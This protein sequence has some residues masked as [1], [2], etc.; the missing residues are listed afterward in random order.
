M[1]DLK[2]NPWD[3]YSPAPVNPTSAPTAKNPWDAYAAPADSAPT[4][5]TPADSAPVTPGRG[6]GA[7]PFAYRTVADLGG[8]PV[9]LV[10]WG[11]SKF[12]V[13]VSKEPFG[14]SA[15]IEN[16]LAK[17]GETIRKPM[18]PEVGQEPKTL[19]EYIGSGLGNA[20][21]FLIPGLSLARLAASSAR[22]VVAAVG[23]QLANA[24]VAAPLSY[25]AA[26]LASGAG[27]GAG[28]YAAEQ[29]APDSKL[30]SFAG[31]ILG[32]LAPS[33]TIPIAKIATGTGPAIAVGKFLT[34][35][36][37][38]AGSRV[39]A[40]NRVQS[41]VADPAF[42]ARA[43]E[44]PSISELT[45][46]QRAGDTGLLSLEK[47]VAETNA[48]K[49]QELRD[50]AEAAQQTLLKEARAL[51]GDPALTKAFF[52]ARRSQ[53]GD[54]LT[55]SVNQARTRAQE[56]IAELDPKASAEDAS[57][58]VRG[59]FD[60]AYDAARAQENRLWRDISQDVQVDTAPLFAKFDEIVSS[61]PR[62]QQQDI[63]AY[64]RSFLDKKNKE[65]LNDLETPSELQGFRSELLAIE[66]RARDAGDRNQA[67]LARE[68]AD[69]TLDAMSSMKNVGDS[70]DAARSFSRQLNET[71]RQGPVGRLIDTTGGALTVPPEMTLTS[72]I[73]GGGVRGGVAERG[74]VA[75]TGE[76]PEVKTAIQDFLTRDLRDRVVTAEGRI[77]P[78][79][80]ET[81]MRRNET[82]LEQ[83]P[84]IRQGLTDALA[85]QAQVGRREGFEKA[86]S[87]QMRTAGG[88]P[89]AQFLDDVS[90]VFK[91]ENP[92]EVAISL[93][94]TAAKDT[95]GQ[96]LL[97]LRGAFVDD[98]FT[99]ARSVTT[100][101]EVFRGSVIVDALKNPKQRG[102]FEA[103]LGAD[104]LKRLEQIG[105][106]FVALERTRG[107]LPSVGGVVGDIPNRIL[108]TLARFGG[109]WFGRL[110]GGLQESAIMSARSR[111]FMR[112]LT[113]DRAEKLISK[114]VTDPELFAA[115]MR[116][117][118]TVQ[119]QDE[120]TRR[121]QGWLAGPAG[122]DLFND[123][124]NESQ[125]GANAVK[126]IYNSVMNPESN[127]A[128]T[129]NLINSP[130]MRNRVGAVFENPAYAG[131]FTA[132]LNREAQF[133]HR[134]D[135]KNGMGWDQS[136]SSL[137]T[138][139]VRN[140]N[141]SPSTAGR[142]EKL[143]TS[144]N[145][146]NLAAAVK[147]L[148]TALQPKR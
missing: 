69:A 129:Q 117:N 128:A 29:A 60:K 64:A 124:S 143:I 56:R 35:P 67:R 61:T 88:A 44:T 94:R 12:G 34:K 36:F 80:A 26:E 114:A 5:S 11:L 50:M 120:T 24:P 147:A 68:L 66:R 137:V 25:T 54:S 48:V 30:A 96:A 136:L 144:N 71:F 112:S 123:E 134:A 78:E 33:A 79:A 99:R 131:L 58:V 101:G 43:M 126:N 53:V 90:R 107:N 20:A 40:Q 13:P 17:Y 140:G 1:S 100:E 95:S 121:L 105:N 37:T 148:E 63:P 132:A 138:N 125:Q 135:Q 142:I 14:G 57:R 27:S 51:G 19:P 85:A 41:L 145:P 97:G 111:D 86:I 116:G 89:L 4:D 59:E 7:I 39:R 75:A 52:E 16:L 28:R 55:A 70:Y 15:S 77:K 23:R 8:A 3:T 118:R 65:R 110:F 91:A 45:P 62:T 106:E 113:R 18:V 32:G 74:I 141:L 92:A 109:A 146:T 108:D 9:D 21:G 31:E 104:D 22:P 119:Q 133:F 49:A 73:G 83:Y 76:T 130:Q 2:K 98:L 81:W 72:L 103:V 87:S 42:V 127:I 38:E 6:G 47:A 139:A 102:A 82:L 93:R 122:R 10:N 115:L 46:A 84:D